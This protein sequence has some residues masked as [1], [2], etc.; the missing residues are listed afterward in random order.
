MARY[1]TL[2]INITEISFLSIRHNA[3]MGLTGYLK[4]KMFFSLFCCI[5]LMEKV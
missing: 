2:Y 5:V 3:H 1:D 4:N